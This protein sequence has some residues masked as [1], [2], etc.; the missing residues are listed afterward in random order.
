MNVKRYQN[1]SD[2]GFTLIELLVVVSI[3]GVI[4]SVGFVS[5]GKARVKTRNSVRVAQMAELRKAMEL[6]FYANQSYPRNGTV[7]NPNEE[8]DIQSLAPFL[9]PTFM[10]YIPNDP[11]PTPEN[12]MYVWKDNGKEF[13]LYIPYGNDDGISCAYKTPGGGTNWFGNVPDCQ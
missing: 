7:G 4:S 13:G 1:K 9:V 5:L 12:Y 8:T 6:Y 10:P 11:R 3:I 2:E